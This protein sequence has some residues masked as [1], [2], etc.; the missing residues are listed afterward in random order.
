MS[1]LNVQA[2]Q[3]EDYTE[4][5]SKQNRFFQDYNFYMPLTA[6]SL[7]ERLSRRPF[8]FPVFDYYVARDA[9]RN[10]VAGMGTVALGQ[11]IPS[12]VTRLP[13]PLKI[14]NLFMHI[15]PSDG[16]IRRILA[17]NFW[18]ESDYPEAAGYLWDSV[19]WLC[20]DEGT[21]V[22]I[23]FDLA[24]PVLKRLDFPRSRLQPPGTIAFQSPIALSENRLMDMYPLSW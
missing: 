16:V 18:F 5:A 13:L 11:L 8:G 22:M 21:S 20:R 4:I 15:L 23:F 9:H 19:R 17:V 3:P 2:A 14:A 6:D 1:G 7:K 12:Q 10:I 24:G